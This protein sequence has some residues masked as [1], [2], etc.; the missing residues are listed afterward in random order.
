M[1]PVLCA[2][3]FFS[4]GCTNDPVG[5]TERTQ[6]RTDADTAQ[7]QAGADAD[8]DIAEQQR[9]ARETEAEQERMARETEAEEDRR[10][11][12]AEADAEAQAR[13]AEAYARVAIHNAW[14]AVV[15]TLFMGFLSIGLVIAYLRS[16][17]E[18]QEQPQPPAMPIM[19][20]GPTWKA[21]EAEAA[22]RGQRIQLTGNSMLLMDN[23]TNAVVARR[24]ISQ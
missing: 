15:I 24:E 13:E 11:R 12:E 17:R 7:V 3:L 5:M 10:A 16:R 23:Q 2:I 18:P 14:G 19:I 9:L 22:S 4:G 1:I 21:L 20:D 6:I 8:V